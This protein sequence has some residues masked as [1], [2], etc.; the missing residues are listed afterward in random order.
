MFRKFIDVPFNGYSKRTPR[1]DKR[2]PYD[3]DFRGFI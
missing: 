3:G 1:L 2:R